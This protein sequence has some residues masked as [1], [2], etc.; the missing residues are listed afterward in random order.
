MISRCESR[1]DPAFSR[2]TSTRTSARTHWAKWAT[3]GTAQKRREEGPQTPR[4][5]PD[6]PAKARSWHG[7]PA[8]RR[9]RAPFGASARTLRNTRA[10]S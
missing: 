7:E 5:P 3:S 8:T 6:G 9:R 10:P 2:A 1:I 4:A